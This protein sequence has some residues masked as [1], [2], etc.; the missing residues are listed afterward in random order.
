MTAI[1][2]QRTQLVVIKRG[3]VCSQSL[4]KHA[5]ASMC[6]S[7]AQLSGPEAAKRSAFVKLKRPPHL[8]PCCRLAK[9][10]IE[11][12]ADQ[13]SGTLAF[14][15]QAFEDLNDQVYREI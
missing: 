12:L 8:C 11:G 9:N 14:E 5:L 6:N 15:G 1:P 13:L 7:R 3:Y 4:L 10:V 2:G